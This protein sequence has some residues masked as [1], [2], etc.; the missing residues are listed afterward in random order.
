MKAA[1]DKSHFFP[2]RVNFLTH[3]IEVTTITPLKLQMYATFKLHH[4]C[5]FETTTI[6]QK[7]KP[8]VPWNV[9][10]SK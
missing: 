1:P 5:N 3:T 2:T 10:L 7:E 8:R 6:Q 4:P 9:K